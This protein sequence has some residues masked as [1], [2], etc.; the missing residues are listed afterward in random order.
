[1]AEFKRTKTVTRR[2]GAKPFNALAP[3]DC[4]AV[5]FDFDVNASVFEFEKFYKATGLS[6]K[7]KRWSTVFYARRA[8]TGFHVHF[9]G[10]L[11]GKD[12]SLSLKYYGRSVVPPGDGRPT[13]E[14]AMKWLGS[15]FKKP[16]EHA[17]VFC[18]FSKPNDGWR[19]RFN[20]P[21]RVTMSGSSTDVV[22]DGIDLELP[23]NRFGAARG[24]INTIDKGL[25]VSV[26]LR[27]N[28][29]FSAFNLENEISAYN[30]AIQIFVEEESGR[31]P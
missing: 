13:A 18:S 23:K 14:T 3:F 20:L 26:A 27:R 1:V 31:R 22:I 4:D 2:K 8:Q 29:E 25:G 12:L 24:W 16:R 28:I 21:F 15:F 30:E 9:D 11:D 7:D 6:A 5:F 10:N 17:L 19:S